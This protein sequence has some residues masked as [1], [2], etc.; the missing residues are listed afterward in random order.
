[1]AE[2]SNGRAGYELPNG[3]DGR[4]GRVHFEDEAP[5]FDEGEPPHGRAR[6][7]D[8]QTSGQQG[9]P[10]EREPQGAEQALKP[11][12]REEFRKDSPITQFS[13][14]VR[15]LGSRWYG[16]YRRGSEKFPRTFALGFGVILPMFSLIFVSLIFGYGLSKV[17]APAEEKKNNGIIG[18]RISL[19][20]SAAVDRIVMADQQRF[21]LFNYFRELEEEVTNDALQNRILNMIDGQIIDFLGDSDDALLEWSGFDL[22]EPKSYFKRYPEDENASFLGVEV[23]NRGEYNMSTISNVTSF[24]ESMENCNEEIFK[25]TRFTSTSNML[26]YFNQYNPFDDV[27]FNWVKCPISKKS[28]NQTNNGSDLLIEKNEMAEFF[29]AFQVESAGN[30][31]KAVTQAWERNFDE[32]FLSKYKSYWQDDG[33]NRLDARTR[34]FEEAFLEAD[35][36]KGCIPDTLS[37]SW[38]WFVF[39]TTI[40]YG[41]ASPETPEGQA[42]SYTFGFLCILMFAM[43]LTKASKIVGMLY[44][45]LVQ[46]H[47]A[48]RWLRRPCVNVIVWAF[49]FYLWLVITA[50]SLMSLRKVGLLGMDLSFSASFWLSFISCTTVGLGDYSI[51]AQDIGVGS[52][53]GLAFLFLVGLTLGAVFISSV[54]DACTGFSERYTRQLEEDLLNHPY[55]K[56]KERLDA[57]PDR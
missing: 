34:A 9:L 28:S 29:A 41:N 21:C 46:Q 40:G 49:Y 24:L 1:M 10:N 4:N 3:S 45:D 6:F 31:L 48:T 18:S 30:Q 51:N 19:Y 23:A 36:F 55:H 42:M 33:N 43:V 15:S 53:F 50:I 27:T 7:E 22:G 39:M 20:I 56:G 47:K 2:N 26:Y 13:H 57:L 25:S 16:C 38:F 8:E 44:D 14:S 54:G 32:L 12:R 17:E 37:A 52:V 5:I 11:G 35:G